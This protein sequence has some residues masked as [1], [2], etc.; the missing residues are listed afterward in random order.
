MILAIDCGNTNMTFALY[1]LSGEK[2]GNWRLKPVLGVRLMIMR[3]PCLALEPTDLPFRRER[4][5]TGICCAR[6]RPI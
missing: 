6:P 3:W 5:C 1:S 2:Q 4:M